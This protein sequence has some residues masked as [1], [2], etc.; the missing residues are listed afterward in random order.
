MIINKNT[1]S[2]IQNK[3][4]DTDLRFILSKNFSSSQIKHRENIRNH[5]EEEFSSH[6]SREQ[7]ATLPDLN[8]IPI[9]SSGFFSI[10]HNQQIGGF[11]YSNL[12]HGFD[13]EVINRISNPIIQ[14]TSSEPERASAPNV[15]FL[16]VAKESA[17]KALP[18]RDRNSVSKFLITD[19]VCYDWQSY[20]NTDVCSFKIKSD[21]PIEQNLNLGFIFLSEDMLFSIYFK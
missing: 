17:L 21:K 4:K 19:L 6:F 9:A 1:V 10:S 2:F 5:L 15:K 16:W 20:S 11:S 7:L 8:Q 3:I 14:R 13:V 12:E 18:N